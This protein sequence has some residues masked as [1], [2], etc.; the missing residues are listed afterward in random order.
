[1]APEAHVQ[2]DTAATLP[3]SLFDG[4]AVA[5]ALAC[6][7]SSAEQAA[8]AAAGLRVAALAHAL[9]H[10]TLP[11][12]SSLAA[13][14]AHCAAAA[15]ALTS[16]GFVTCSSRVEKV[17]ASADKGTTKLLVRLADGL[18]VEA[19]L[20][21]HDSGAGKYAGAPRPGCVPLS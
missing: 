2:L 17:V 21:R 9:R 12:L 14:G 15:A 16:S 4:P 20:L 6:S 8:R 3:L 18:A 11:L 7:F 13:E 1:M 19:V 10:G 5:A